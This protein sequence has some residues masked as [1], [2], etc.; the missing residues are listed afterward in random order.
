[1]P[2]SMSSPTARSH[3]TIARATSPA[4]SRPSRL[5]AS[6][7]T[8]TRT[9]TTV[10]PWSKG[11]LRGRSPS[12]LPIGSSRGR[13]RARKG[14]AALTLFSYF[15]EVSKIFEELVEGPA[16]VIGLDLV[17]GAAT[18]PAIA[19]H[20]S[21]K[22]LVLGLVDA[23]NTKKEDPAEVA[24]KVLDLKDRIDLKTSFLAPSNG[25]EFLPRNRAR[26]KLRIL[27]TAARQVGVAA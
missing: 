8:S 23:R 22:P 25:L 2:G 18:W 6:H 27:S 16:D 19:K 20:G 5:T 10:S 1:M 24:K 7:G 14:S 15:G 11:P 9:H 26:E 13:I 21:K 4:D 12:S 3:G 17:Q